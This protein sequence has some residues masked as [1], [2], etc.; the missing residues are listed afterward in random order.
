M[1]DL[2]RGGP[3]KGS[4]GERRRGEDERK[5]RPL[6][7]LLFVLIS[8]YQRNSAPCDTD[9]S[10]GRSRAVQPSQPVIARAGGGRPGRAA[11]LGPPTERKS[12]PTAMP[13]RPCWLLGR[14]RRDGGAGGGA[15]VWL[16]V[17]AAGPAARSAA[18]A[19]GRRG[20]A[21]SD[22]ACCELETRV[23][24]AIG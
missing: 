23:S 4:G 3:S 17:R 20:F 6:L 15:F 19:T 18:H 8:S 11:P 14:G 7:V 21:V 24:A 2:G 16:L 1:R 5:P 13:R 10:F 9:I 22:T 12:P